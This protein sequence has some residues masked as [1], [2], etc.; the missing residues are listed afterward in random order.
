M[1]IQKQ[2]QDK[3][4]KY[5]NYA[6]LVMI[7]VFLFILFRQQLDFY[8]KSSETSKT[9]VKGGDFISQ[10]EQLYSSVKRTLPAKGLYRY[11]SDNIADGSEFLMYYYITQYCLAPR[12]L[13]DSL[14]TDTMVCNFYKTQSIN[15]PKNPLYATRSQWTIIDDNGAGVM[16]LKKNKP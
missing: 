7:C 8:S 1:L 14:F 10:K 3:I 6:G 13:T 4:K 9:I 5:L 15:N 2:L 11:Q 16:V 12:V